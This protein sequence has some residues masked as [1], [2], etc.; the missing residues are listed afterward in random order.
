MHAR[1]YTSKRHHRKY[2]L[3]FKLRGTADRPRL[4]VFRSAR[5]IYAQVID[6]ES[7]TTLAAASTRDPA[8]AGF[9]GSKVAKAR[10][11]GEL[12]VHRTLYAGVQ[13]LVFDRNG[14]LYTG[15]VA[16]VSRAAHKAGLLKRQGVDAAV[17][18]AAKAGPVEAPPPVIEE[19]KPKAKAR[20][21]KGGKGGKG[22]KGRRTRSRWFG[23]QLRT[24]LRGAARACPTLHN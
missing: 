11:V 20:S 21:A 1:R 8:M 7:G 19:E 23:P 18:A 6:D 4:S 2:R 17:I 13:K 14:F 9:E 24:H 10:R 12:I 15:R 3:R 5:H 16:A 22:G